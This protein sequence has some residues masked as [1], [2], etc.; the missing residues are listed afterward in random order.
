MC[1]VVPILTKKA[2]ESAGVEKHSLI[3]V[4]IFGFFRIGIFRVAAIRASWAYPIP[5]TIC[6]E[7]V[8]IAGEIPFV[9][10]SS[11][12]FCPDVQSCPTESLFPWR[13]PALIHTELT[14]SP[15]F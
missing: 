7:R 3:F 6:R 13:Y 14:D 4:S 1:P 8:V 5:H 11:D 15:E 9:G 2:I 12:N 10:P